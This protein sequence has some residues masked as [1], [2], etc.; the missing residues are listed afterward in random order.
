M[1]KQWHIRFLIVVMVSALTVSA[2]PGFAQGDRT[3]I[4]ADNAANL[5]ELI[6]LGRGS[7]EYA[8]WSPDG[9]T[10]YIGGTVGL[11]AYDPTNIATDAEPP[12][13]NVGGEIEGLAVSPVDGSI[14]TA[15]RRSDA[16]IQW[17]AAS[18]SETARVEPENG[19]GVISISP[20]GQYLAVNH[21]S[22]GFTIYTTSNGQVFTASEDASLDSDL[23]LEFSPDS[24]LLAGANT[25]GTIYVWEF[26]TTGTLT[27]LSGHSGGIEGLAFTP[28]S[29][30]LVSGSTDDT[31]RV[32]NPR[33]TAAEPVVVEGAEDDPIRD[34][35]DVAVTADGTIISGHSGVVRVW[36]AGGNQT[37]MFEVDGA[38]GNARD[39]V[40]SPDSSQF[41]VLTSNYPTQ[42]QLWGTD[43]TRIG[44]ALGHNQYMSSVRFS[45][46]SSTLAMSDGD[47]FLY[48]W[49]TATV[50]EITTAIKIEDGTGT[51]V[52]NLDGVAYASDGSVMA[53][54][55]SFGP[56]LRDPATGELL[57]ELEADGLSSDLAF[58]PDNTLL[59][60]SSSQGVYVFNV[61]DGTLLASSNA[62]NDWVG[63]I[64]WSPDQ[65]MIASAAIDHTVRVWVVQ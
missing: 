60:Y 65:T 2:L 31:V 48:L 9:S 34:A 19:T 30:A 8:A 32:W 1:L 42:L 29:A 26:A 25:S 51:G 59:A 41:A 58:S 11:W 54:L 15:D 28:D 35:Y 63:D 3:V 61:A 39:I 10:L 46:D 52:E 53:T 5:S 23:A 22:R 18:L 49:D 21:G 6:R 20:D 62:H 55:N 33:D 17:D 44:T 57:F 27:E 14:Y 37:A 24:S 40:L 16:I 50:G 4:T 7:A 45:P 38:T 64:T 12:L 36:D 56:E 43:G 47:S 13:V